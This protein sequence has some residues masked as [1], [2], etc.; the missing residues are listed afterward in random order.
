MSPNPA[1]GQVNITLPEGLKDASRIDVLD[2]S[3]RLVVSMRI[4]TDN[5]KLDVS[6]LANG[7]Y[8]I[9]AVVDDRVSGGARL[10]VVH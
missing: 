1:D 10:T 5:T 8:V 6:G 2:L 9:R 4:G 7:T 3:G